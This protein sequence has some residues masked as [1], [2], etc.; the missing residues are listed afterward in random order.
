MLRRLPC[1]SPDD[2]GVPLS[3]P[4]GSHSLPPR[5]LRRHWRHSSSQ[6]TLSHFSGIII[7][8]KDFDVM[9]RQYMDHFPISTMVATVSRV[10]VNSITSDREYETKTAFSVLTVQGPIATANIWRA[11]SRVPGSLSRDLYAWTGKEWKYERKD[12]LKYPSLPFPPSN[13]IRTLI[14]GV[15]VFTVQPLTSD[16][17]NRLR[18]QIAARLQERD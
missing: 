12:Q 9:K 1:R 14:E 2:S 4:P 7:A 10:F 6:E 5:R 15:E 11:S 18:V 13:A 3:A 8:S 17:E 16:E